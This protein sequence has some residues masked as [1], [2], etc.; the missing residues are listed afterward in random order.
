MLRQEQQLKPYRRVKNFEDMTLYSPE[1]ELIPLPHA[2]AWALVVHVLFSMVPIVV[3]MLNPTAFIAKPPQIKYRDMEFV[4]V[5]QPE[6]E[7]INKNT[8]LRAEQN[9]QAGGIHDPNK[10]I[11]PPEPALPKSAPSQMG[12]D[13]KQKVKEQPAPKKIAQAQ[14]QQPVVKQEPKKEEPPKQVTK[15]APKPPKVAARTSLP[16][17]KSP[18]T[19]KLPVPPSSDAPKIAA[20]TGPVTSKPSGNY[21]GNSA[22]SNPKP[23]IASSGGSG[24]SG[25]G[26]GTKSSSD[27]GNG[28]GS[29]YSPGGG[30]AGN[31][32]PGNPHGAPGVDAVKEPNFGP[33]MSDLQ[34]RIKANWDP[35]RGDESKRVVLLFRIAKDGR[36]LSVKVVKSSGSQ[37][38]DRAALAAVELTAPFRALPSDYRGAD[39]DIQ[40]TFDYNVFGV[41]K[42]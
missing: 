40:F 24:A 16:A 39:V 13:K 1:E 4:L 27:T 34:R 14:P 31:P 35:P 36:L 6:K 23:V 8:P 32:G 18:N 5:N 17:S 3:L 19:M 30:N 20:P 41:N 7:P 37:A 22:S 2:M 26:T 33:Y 10:P 21:K 28:K 29:T 38:A 12:N 25:R 15:P 42:Y 11:S 9:S